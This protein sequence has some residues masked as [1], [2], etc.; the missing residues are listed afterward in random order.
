V[1]L[2]RD[3]AGSLGLSIAGGR[4][5]PMGDMPIMV[6][7]LAPQGPAHQ[8]GNIQ[9]GD[10][11]LS[12]NHTST[13]GM[14]HDQAIHLLKTSHGNTVMLEIAQGPD[15]SSSS[16]PS[17]SPAASPTPDSPQPPASPEADTYCTGTLRTI[18]L[19]RGVGGLGFSIVGGRGSPHGNLPIYVKT[20][21]GEG[22]AAVD[23]RLKRGDQ[24]VAVNRRSL[25]NMAHDE[26]VLVL[27][28]AHGAVELTILS[29]DAADAVTTPQSM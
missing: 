11:V 27:K 2:R 10:L 1:E 16:S 7:G 28:Q 22:A 5:S 6:A 3:T 18:V 9:A 29:T 15:L 26:A 8:A 23:G 19:E 20:V 14:S 24:I 12:I 21:F 25:E 4:D 13:I 17:S